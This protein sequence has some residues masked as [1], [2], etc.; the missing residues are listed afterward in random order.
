[1]SNTEKISIEDQNWEALHVFWWYRINDDL[2]SRVYSKNGAVICIE[3]N[4]DVFLGGRWFIGNMREHRMIEI[5]KA[6]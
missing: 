3:Q 2:D 1:M 6:N 5:F 4:Q